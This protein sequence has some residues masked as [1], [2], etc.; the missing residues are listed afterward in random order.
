MITHR[1]DL[2]L[3]P[4]HTVQIPGAA[5]TPGGPNW[6]HARVAAGVPQ[7]LDAQMVRERV[8]LWV[9]CDPDAE[10]APVTFAVLPTGSDIPEGAAYVSTCVGSSGEWQVFRLPR[11]DADAES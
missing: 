10:A 2:E 6:E 11:K 8:R 9:L 3:S 7:I 5:R 4:S 1:F